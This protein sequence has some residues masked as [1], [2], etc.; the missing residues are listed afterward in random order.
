MQDAEGPKFK[1]PE[2]PLREKIAHSIVD[3]LGKRYHEQRKAAIAA[4]AAAK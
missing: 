4:A 2:T 1:I 3:T